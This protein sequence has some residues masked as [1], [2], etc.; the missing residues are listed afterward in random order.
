MVT[1]MEENVTAG[2]QTYSNYAYAFCLYPETLHDL[3]KAQDA[4]PRFQRIQRTAQATEELKRHLQRGFM[5][6]EYM[7]RI[8]VDDMPELGMSAALWIPVQAYYAV[9]G[10]GLATLSAISGQD[11]LSQTHQTHRAFLKEAENQLIRRLLPDPFKASLTGG[12]KGDNF[13]NFNKANLLGLTLDREPGDWPDNLEIPNQETRIS[14]IARCL[15]TTRERRLKYKFRKKRE[16]DRIDRLSPEEKTKIMH[17][18]GDTTIFNYLY[19]I[20]LHS[21]YDNPNLFARAVENKPIALKFVKNNQEMTKRL[22]RLLL[23]IIE[24]RLKA[25]DYTKLENECRSGVEWE[26]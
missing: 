26:E 4:L 21:N 11:N 9:H 7:Q 19:R 2:M 17:Q 25:D 12:F 16:N 22:C 23:R 13:S 18:T 8:P 3:E 1:R 20:R 6:L 24:R 10:F 5:T 14:H 15:S